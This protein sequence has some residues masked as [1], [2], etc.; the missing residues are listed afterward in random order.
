M[1]KVLSL[2]N[3]FMH[4]KFRILKYSIPETIALFLIAAFFI[5]MLSL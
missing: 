3:I 5:V 1:K 4:D 2:F